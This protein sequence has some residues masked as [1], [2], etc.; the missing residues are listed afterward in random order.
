MGIEQSIMKVNFEDVKQIENNNNFL[1]INTLPSN[2]Q[3]C[4]IKGTIPIN[5]EEE[6]INKNL[7]NNKISIIIYGKNS[8]D[9]KIFKKYK[10][11]ISLGFSKVYI[12]P[13]GL[14]EWLCLQDIYG[15]FEFSTIGNELDILKYKAKSMIT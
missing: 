13:G 4:L 5:N 15:K 1:L 2:D 3:T 6:I 9:D 7:K 11:L 12:Y 14:F 8:N 10:Q